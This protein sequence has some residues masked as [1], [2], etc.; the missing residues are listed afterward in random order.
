M[1]PDRLIHRIKRINKSEQIL[2][3]AKFLNEEVFV[4]SIE[5]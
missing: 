1:C 5:Y 4:E 2:T 3:I